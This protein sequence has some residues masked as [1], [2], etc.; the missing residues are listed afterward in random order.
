MV[1]VRFLSNRELFFRNN[2]VNQLKDVLAIH[3][4]MN[5]RAFMVHVQKILRAVRRGLRT[6]R[7]DVEGIW[8]L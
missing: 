1:L 8:T 3:S 5:R 4:G 7:L 6:Y 2:C